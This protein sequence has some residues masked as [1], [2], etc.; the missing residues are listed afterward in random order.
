MGSPGSK[1]S[2]C[3]LVRD[4]SSQREFCVV[5]VLVLVSLPVLVLLL[6]LVLVLLPV[7]VLDRH[8]TKTSAQ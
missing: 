5:L 3:L 6:V 7:L 2:P 1:D 8:Q 4:P